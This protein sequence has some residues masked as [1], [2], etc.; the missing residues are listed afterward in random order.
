MPKLRMSEQEKQDKALRLAIARG[1]AGLGI[2]TQ[3]TVADMIEVTPTTYSNYKKT[4][5]HAMNIQTLRKLA[6]KLPFTGR[7]ICAIIGVR[8]EE[9][10]Y[11]SE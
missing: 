10:T 4:N 5:Y 8:Y 9:D 2:T 11:D 1:M 7:E 3:A 6:K